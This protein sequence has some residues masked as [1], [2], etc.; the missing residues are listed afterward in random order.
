MSRR[1]APFT[2]TV[3]TRLIKGAVAAGIDPETIV[4]I[5]ATRDGLKLILGSRDEVSKGAVNE[6][7]EVFNDPS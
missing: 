3:V 4:G 2:Q 1:A 5:E 6:W 7:D